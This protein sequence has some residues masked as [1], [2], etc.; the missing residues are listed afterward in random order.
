MNNKRSGAVLSAPSAQLS[1]AVA[2]TNAALK[3]AAPATKL[4]KLVNVPYP[5]YLALDWSENADAAIVAY[6]DTVG[7]G[8][9]LLKLV[10]KDLTVEGG[11]YLGTECI[12]ITRFPMSR[13]CT[14]PEQM[15]NKD[16]PNNPNQVD[17]KLHLPI[18]ISDPHLLHCLC[19]MMKA[20]ERAAVKC[21]V[22][23]GFDPDISDDGVKRRVR[24]CFG[25]TVP[26]PKNATKEEKAAYYISGA[27]P[28][29]AGPDEY[30]GTLRL[31]VV[32]TVIKWPDAAKG[33]RDAEIIGGF[34][35]AAAAIEEPPR[36]VPLGRADLT[37]GSFI[38]PKVGLCGVNLAEGSK[39]F[40]WWRLLEAFVKPGTPMPRGAA[41]LSDSER[42]SIRAAMATFEPPAAAAEGDGGGEGAKGTT[43][44]QEFLQKILDLMAELPEPGGVTSEKIAACL[45]APLAEVKEALEALAREMLVYCTTDTNHFRLVNEGTADGEQPDAKRSRTE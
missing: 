37:M 19:E 36:D 38:A 17:T 34:Y 2:A 11:K 20:Y 22:E 6:V 16:S 44:D 26:I 15:G 35:D 24:R 42:A 40:V 4:A 7:G 10:R 27:Y 33:E 13:V 1:P 31:D 12:P 25:W 29:A 28:R 39:A 21:R 30:D 5:D 3:K 14:K 23:L 8:Q 41:G 45:G 32:S 9:K 18:G 43:S